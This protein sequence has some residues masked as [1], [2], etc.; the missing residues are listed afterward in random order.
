MLA[1]ALAAAAAAESL[2]PAARALPVS[3]PLP[4]TSSQRDG[5]GRERSP[6]PT[7][8]RAAARSAPRLRNTRLPPSP[9]LGVKLARL[10]NATTT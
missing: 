9:R 4:P 10:F 1:R 3:R 5:S 6:P 7:R 8:P 2:P